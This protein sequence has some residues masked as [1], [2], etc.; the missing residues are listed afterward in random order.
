MCTK[1]QIRRGSKGIGKE[2]GNGWMEWEIVEVLSLPSV[3]F[4]AAIP[5]GP[6]LLFCFSFCGNSNGTAYLHLSI[7]GVLFV[8]F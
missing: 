4:A 8:F 5:G 6:S 1:H 3:V 7:N 2:I